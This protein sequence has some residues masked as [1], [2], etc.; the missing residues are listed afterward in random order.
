MRLGLRCLSMFAL[1][2]LGFLYLQRCIMLLKK[3]LLA[4]AEYGLEAL[5]VKKPR[6]AAQ[7]VPTRQPASQQPLRPFLLT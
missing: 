3:E 5:L 6:A 2:G 4:Q 7:E 1:M